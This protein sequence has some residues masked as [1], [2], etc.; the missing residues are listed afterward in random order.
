MH[1]SLPPRI[2]TIKSS[3]YFTLSK[4]ARNGVSAN[5]FSSRS[6]TGIYS[7]KSL[8]AYTAISSRRTHMF[9][10]SLI[11]IL[12]LFFGPPVFELSDSDYGVG[13]GF[14]FLDF[15]LF[16]LCLE[17]GSLFFFYLDF[18]SRTFTIHKTVEERGDYFLNSFLSLPPTSHTLRH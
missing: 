11:R 4:L 17:A 2:E 8:L 13:K 6:P 9:S 16:C 5:N 7:L 10:Y 1:W 12:K 3:T 18:L 14:L 15:F